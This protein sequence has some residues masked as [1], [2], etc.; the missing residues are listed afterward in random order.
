[1]SRSK[2]VQ[3]APFG[4]AIIR[5][6]NGTF[7]ITICDAQTEEEA[8]ASLEEMGAPPTKV[9]FIGTL[10]KQGFP[11]QNAYALLSLLLEQSFESDEGLANLL[12]HF[13]LDAFRA[14][15]AEGLKVQSKKE[16]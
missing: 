5:E 16:E 3:Y 11:E 15:Y 2:K 12:A 14:G 1:M 4:F 6:P 10:L 9:A 13:V 7:T 8:L